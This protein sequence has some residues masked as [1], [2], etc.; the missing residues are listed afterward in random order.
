[1]NHYFFLLIMTLLP[2]DIIL[3]MIK[4]TDYPKSQYYLRMI[5]KRI[6]K[7]KIELPKFK[8]SKSEKVKIMKKYD[9]TIY[10][11]D[12]YDE[13]NEII[14]LD[15]KVIMLINAL[16]M[17]EHIRYNSKI[18]TYCISDLDNRFN[19]GL[20]TINNNPQI[21][22]LVLFTF[23]KSSHD[24]LVENINNNMFD[25]FFPNVT[26]LELCVDILADINYELI[27]TVKRISIIINNIYCFFDLLNIVWQNLQPNII[28]DI[29]YYINI[30]YED[31]N[32]KIQVFNDTTSKLCIKN[33]IDFPV[34]VIFRYDYIKPHINIL[35]V[36]MKYLD[37]LKTYIRSI[38]MV[39]IFIEHYESE[40][41]ISN[42]EYLEAFLLDLNYNIKKI[43]IRN[44]P[45]LEYI[46]ITNNYFKVDLY[47]ENL[48]SLKFLKI[49]RSLY[50][51]HCINTVI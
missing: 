29:I 48:P 11:Y 22:K 5:Y 10:G 21:N 25:K 47:L 6:M 30:D 38:Y 23:S 19:N 9:F 33:A 37:A 42:Y 15:N 8:L 24:I 36:T 40:V 35:E 49:N 18:S 26:E 2:E 4:C 32:Q 50:N 3:H 14:S 51:I 12:M 13:T 16:D 31:Y 44:C 34:N 27:S 39:F 7:D 43:L 20:I 28:Y 1:M 41:Y 45:N 46:L 17:F